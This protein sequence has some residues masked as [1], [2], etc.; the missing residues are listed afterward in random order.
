MATGPYPLPIYW[1]HPNILGE[2]TFVK[3]PKSTRTKQLKPNTSKV[4]KEYRASP[5]KNGTPIGYNLPYK[6]ELI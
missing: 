2:N 1:E 5:K 6:T 4:F 3:P